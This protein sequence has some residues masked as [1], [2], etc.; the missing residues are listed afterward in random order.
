MVL[1]LIVSVLVLLHHSALHLDGIGSPSYKL[2]FDTRDPNNANSEQISE[3]KILL[4]NTQ[5]VLHEILDSNI[6]ISPKILQE[7]G[8]LVGSDIKLQNDH[9]PLLS[10]TNQMDQ[11][12]KCVDETKYLKTK[13]QD[14]TDSKDNS[15]QSSMKWLVIGIPTVSRQHDE[16]YLLDS[17]NTLDHQLPNDPADP[18]Y[19]KVLI[20]IINLQK[21]T[22][23]IADH[24]VY[25]RAKE[26][27]QSSPYYRFT[28]IDSS[29]TLPDA[30][31]PNYNAKN[32][33]GNANK[34][35]Y[36]VRRQTRNIYTVMMHNLDV[37]EHYLFLEDD[38]QF[39]HNGLLAIQYLI[40]KAN[41]YHPNWLA[42][43]ASYGMNGIFMHN[44]DLRVFAE[45]LLKHQVRR[46]PDHLVVEWYAGETK[47]SK[48]HK[49]DRVNIGFRFNIFNHIGS[50]STLRSKKSGSFPKCYE[51]LLEP[52]VFEVEAF[53][54]KQCP[55]D[56]IWPCHNKKDRDASSQRWVKWDK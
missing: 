56:D 36:L 27:Y 44:K 38:M 31:G 17:L 15:N 24:T 16:A 2:G 46:P 6:S 40:N 37:A 3:L 9:Q 23:R 8:D 39:C 25:N 22:E 11:L 45:Y 48:S 42:I 30:K 26:K 4:V 28:E 1:L 12:E 14:C 53:S 52:T 54:L 50:V 43:R 7:M 18:L 55:H 41:R 20:H 5:K 10:T 33:P 21:N 19:H 32:D 35:G 49:G 13:L 47:E 51:M 34:P 29:D